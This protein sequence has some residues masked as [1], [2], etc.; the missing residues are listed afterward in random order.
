MYD[1]NDRFDILLFDTISEIK[2][3][4]E[5]LLKDIEAKGVC[6]FCGTKENIS[7]F[8]SRTHYPCDVYQEI[9]PNRDLFLCECC[10]KEYNY[11]WDEQWAE[12]YSSR[13]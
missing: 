7:L 12:Y 8:C 11:N 9:D 5:K 1:I 6:E 3:K 4:R 2:E 10:G 13:L